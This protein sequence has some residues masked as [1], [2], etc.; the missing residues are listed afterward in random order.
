MIYGIDS[1]IKIN[2]GLFIG[3]FKHPSFKK[4]YDI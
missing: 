1:F 3:L 2:K 4:E